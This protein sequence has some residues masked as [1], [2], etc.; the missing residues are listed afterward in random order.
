MKAPRT[1]V[2]LALAGL[3]A[4]PEYRALPQAESARATD[5]VQA[6]RSND[7]ARA[8][9]IFSELV[10]TAPTATNVSYLA[11]AEFSAGHVDQSLAHFQQAIRLGN[12]SAS[13]HY[14]FGL[15]CLRHGDNDLGIRQLRIVLEKDPHF[16]PAR[17]A[18]GAALLNA[19]R[20][21]QAIPYLE[22][23]RAGSQH[24]A[25][26]WANLVRAYFEAGDR[27]KALETTDNALDAVPDDPRLAST[28]AFLCLHHQQPQKA[29]NLLENASE[30][31][32]QD[33]NLKILLAETSIKAGE[34]EEAL[35]VLKDVPP[36]AGAA[37]ELPFLR[38]T[39]YLLGGDLEESRRNL[40]EAIGAQPSNPDY[41]FAYAGLQGSELLY[42]EALAT[43]EKAQQLAPQSEPIL[44]QTAV[45]Y[46]LMG[47]YQDAV[48]TCKQALQRP[49]ARDE[50]YFLMGV[51]SLEEHN[52]REA[53][54]ELEKAVAL[55]SKVAA[56]HGALGVALYENHDLK[57]SLAE[58]DKSLSLDPQ[59]APAYLWRSRAYSQEGDNARASADSQTYAALS[60]SAHGNA[61][62]QPDA[63][64]A[65][66]PSKAV[67]SS[68]KNQDEGSASFLDQLWLTRLREGLGEVGG[69]H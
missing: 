46:A 67:S 63:S 6:L 16:D 5:G 7:F 69:G 28:L 59:A 11:I 41:L 34:P 17:V 36:E 65:P 13:L 25:E 54:A 61:G 4:A 26:F 40:A 31:A 53:Q 64:G 58:L 42:S 37:G 21:P 24:D 66:S 22:Q 45:T 57:G 60:A 33:N 9:Q 29:R 2:V 27:K 68:P 3:L 14:Y 39:A 50:V 52:F 48:L 47:R 38:G 20:A 23:A 62:P 44:Y 10:K 1:F 43:L 56:Y 51:I 8:E 19:G 18:L 49:S 55:D 32:P 35:A 12:D 15:A 30:L